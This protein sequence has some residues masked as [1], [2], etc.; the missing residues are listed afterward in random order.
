RP[1]RRSPGFPPPRPPG[2]E[3]GGAAPR[4]GRRRHPAG[5]PPRDH[6]PAPL[7]RGGGRARAASMSI[8]TLTT[9]FGAADPFVG[10]MKGVIAGRAPTARV[11]DLTHGVPP[12]DV[13]AGAL[14]LRHSVPY[15]PRSTI[16]LAVV[17][18]GVGSEGRALCVESAGAL[19]VGP[20]KG[21][22][23]LDSP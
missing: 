8:I 13:L 4:G 7:G 22:L 1:P 6:V 10:V 23:S 18:P 15:F 19:L 14:I 16:D 3:R 21:L 2:R 17:D 11:I 12:H 20:D 9:D 5:G